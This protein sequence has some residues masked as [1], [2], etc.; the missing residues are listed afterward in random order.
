M[1]MKRTVFLFFA[2][3]GLVAA[4]TGFAV[5][6]LSAAWIEILPQYDYDAVTNMHRAGDTVELIGHVFVSQ[7]DWTN[8]IPVCWEIDGQYLAA[9]SVYGTT[10]FHTVSV[11]QSFT[12][13]A[14]RHEISFV[15]D[16]S[17]TITELSESNNGITDITDARIVGF[18]FEQGFIR[19]F[20]TTQWDWC[21]GTTAEGRVSIFDWA[22]AQIIEYNRMFRDAT[23]TVTGRYRLG[24]VS[25]HPDGSLPLYNPGSD[26]WK[27]NRPAF[28]KRPD[29]MWGF[30]TE[31]FGP[32]PWYRY[33]NPSTPW[34]IDYALIHELGHARYLID[35]YGFD[36]TGPEVKVE[37]KG[38]RIPGTVWMPYL[39]YDVVYYNKWGWYTE[40]ND[41]MAHPS[42]TISPATSWPL[43][44]IAGR[45]AVAGN[46]NAPGN[47]GEYLNDYSY[48]NYVRIINKSTKQPVPDIRVE[49]YQATYDPESEHFYKKQFDNTVD[50]TVYTDSNGVAY[51]ADPFSDGHNISGWHRNSMLLL[52]LTDNREGIEFKFQEI[53]EYNIA[54]WKG[55]VNA[56]TVTVQTSLSQGS[57]TQDFSKLYLNDLYICA[58]GL[59]KDNFR[60]YQDTMFNDDVPGSG[61]DGGKI[62]VAVLDGC[63]G[64]G[65]G[66]T[67]TATVI[68]AGVSSAQWF[69]A[70]MIDS[71][72]VQQL[73]T[74]IYRVLNQPAYT[75]LPTNASYHAQFIQNA[76]MKKSRL[77]VPLII[78]DNWF[79]V[80]GHDAMEINTSGGLGLFISN[81]SNTLFA[82]GGHPSLFAMDY[83]TNWDSGKGEIIPGYVGLQDASYFQ[84]CSVTARA[85]CD[86]KTI[87]EYECTITFLDFAGDN[88]TAVNPRGLTGIAAPGFTTGA[89]IGW[90]ALNSGLHDH[91]AYFN[92][93]VV[94]IPEPGNVAIII[95]A[96]VG[97]WRR[98]TI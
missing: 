50:L 43:N 61:W 79:T 70:G 12:W 4:S 6:D 27:R 29:V 78:G 53:T 76:G 75:Q 48:N 31:Y 72:P 5:T 94:F 55:G 25:I 1:D 45:R 80:V 67:P 71:V 85:E 57:Y 91:R 49:I 86:L 21:Q 60:Y 36:T 40:T 13:P 69:Q 74:N 11:T 17:N 2:G 38:R 87:G 10:Q 46:Y 15:V 19:N 96:W 9:G 47:L 65:L 44:R 84:T 88:D 89:D 54:Y 33:D 41:F 98:I 37:Y 23:P 97:F 34:L 14:G 8:D 68:D 32:P 95:I 56:A 90:N 77:N 42:D 62:D 81:A 35:L 58:S 66:G 22:Q 59:R 3:L 92:V 39:N 73:D 24:L 28:D 93:Q 83:G 7:D 64:F 18:W 51:V 20:S 63:Y 52:K 30:P 26:P 16:P 82:I